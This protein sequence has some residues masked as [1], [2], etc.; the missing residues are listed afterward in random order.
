MLPKTRRAAYVTSYMKQAMQLG[1]QQQ[2]QQQL[3]LF[4]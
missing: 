1:V 2:Q 4:A 3:V